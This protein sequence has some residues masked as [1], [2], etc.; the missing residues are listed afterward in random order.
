MV[1]ARPSEFAR[2]RKPLTLPS[3]AVS[4]NS[5]GSSA[6]KAAKVDSLQKLVETFAENERSLRSSVKK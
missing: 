1:K 3:L 4:K 6:R 2:S 5:K